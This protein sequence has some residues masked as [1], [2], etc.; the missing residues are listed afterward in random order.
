M[1]Q[2]MSWF[3]DKLA[4]GMQ[5]YSVIHG[6]GQSQVQCRRYYL[7]FWLDP[8]YPSITYLSDIYRPYRI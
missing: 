4:P 2:I 3:T 6:L 8:S 1:N 5:K 7:S